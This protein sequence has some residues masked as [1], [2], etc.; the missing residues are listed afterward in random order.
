MR[1]STNIVKDYLIVAF[2]GELDHHTTEEARMKI[3]SLYYDN[4]LSNMILDLRKLNFMDS[5]GI[6]LIMGRY[7]NCKERQG[8]ISIVNT[9]PS[10][11]R[12]LRMSG[13]LKIINMYSNI[14]E[15][16][17]GKRGE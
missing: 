2:E 9:N 8:D 3:D 15:A 12:I 10:V 1:L 5:S 17:D 13:L 11:E 4:N 6:G 14:E 16:I 7:R